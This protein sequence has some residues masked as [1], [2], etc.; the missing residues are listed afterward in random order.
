MRIL[1][2][3]SRD[4]NEV[5]EI[6]YVFEN[7]SKDDIIIHGGA[8]G[9]DSIAGWIAKQRGMEVKEFPAQWK[10]HGRA[11]GPIR[12]QQM[13]NEGK[14][15]KAYAFYKDKSKSRGTADMVRRCKKAGI[16]IHENK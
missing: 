13:I 12:N 15:D 14:P 16:P 10:K 1:I 9:A 6:L 2:C 4:F 5:D 7:L 3:G 8:R 11:A